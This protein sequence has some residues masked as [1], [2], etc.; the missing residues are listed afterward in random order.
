MALLQ[1][2]LPSVQLHFNERI[3][4]CEVYLVPRPYLAL[5]MTCLYFCVPCTLM[6]IIYA[7]IYAKIVDS[8]R[9]I[10]AYEDDAPVPGK[11]NRKKKKTNQEWKTAKMVIT[12]I[13]LFFVLWLP[14]FSV[15]C[16][17]SYLPDVVPGW[18]ERLAYVSAYLNSC[19]NFVVYSIMNRN[20]R[21]AFKKLLPRVPL[22]R[23]SDTNNSNHVTNSNDVTSRQTNTNDVIRKMS[24]TISSSMKF[25]VRMH[26]ESTGEYVIEHMEVNEGAGR[27]EGDSIDI[28]SGEEGEHSHTISDTL[29]QWILEA[30][31]EETNDIHLKC[32]VESH[33]DEIASVNHGFHSSGSKENAEDG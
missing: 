12:V 4:S 13:G 22:C 15:V 29:P 17:K 2:I 27:E 19:A 31:R 33:L 30:S 32:G 26:K 16:I 14:Y 25:P 7:R 28:S 21:A 8:N 5:L 11:K 1:R 18:L 20:M 9:K 6:V 10:S 3:L 24:R 23:H